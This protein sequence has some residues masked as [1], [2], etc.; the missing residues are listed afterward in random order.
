MFE[1]IELR[2]AIELK[3]DAAEMSEE[4]TQRS[5]MTKKKSFPAKR[6]SLS[7]IKKLTKFRR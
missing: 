7:N 5:V 4:T 3:E 6:S 1:S 2:A